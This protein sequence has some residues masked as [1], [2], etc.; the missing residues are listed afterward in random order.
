MKVKVIAN[1]TLLILMCIGQFAFG[2]AKISFYNQEI[3]VPFD[4]SPGFFLN[5]NIESAKGVDNISETFFRDPVTGHRYDY[6]PYQYT[7]GEDN[8]L[9]IIYSMQT[10]FFQNARQFDPFRTSSRDV[11]FIV[12]EKDGQQ[13]S[14]LLKLGM[15]YRDP[16]YQNYENYIRKPF[17]HRVYFNYPWRV[18]AVI[19][20]QVVQGDL[21]EKRHGVDNFVYYLKKYVPE[22]IDRF[23][24]KAMCAGNEIVKQNLFTTEATD[25]SCEGR[26]RVLQE[27]CWDLGRRLQYSY[28]QFKL[29]L[30]KYTCE[31]VQKGFWIFES[32]DKK[33]YEVRMQP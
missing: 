16:V 1:F 17:R 18:D 15:L 5:I 29:S 19:N 21:Y 3:P 33:I 10:G 23:D 22:N 26:L 25:Q 8:R 2:E 20:G 27:I 14:R 13:T 11:E 6:K 31:P 30:P 7:K 12:N 32:V 28:E 24:F 4:T 9:Y